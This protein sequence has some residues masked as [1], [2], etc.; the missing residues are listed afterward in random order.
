MTFAK[1][2]AILITATNFPEQASEQSEPFFLF[3]SRSEIVW[4]EL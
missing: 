3:V 4:L 2:G 1:L